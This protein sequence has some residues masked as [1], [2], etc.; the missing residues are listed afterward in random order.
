MS[1]MTMVLFDFTVFFSLYSTLWLPAKVEVV[2]DHTNRVSCRVFYIPCNYRNNA[3]FENAPPPL[4]PRT[5]FKARYL[6]S[7]QSAI[8]DLMKQATGRRWTDDD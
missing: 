1:I 3:S 2:L 7:I 8:A 6:D 4:S 5:G